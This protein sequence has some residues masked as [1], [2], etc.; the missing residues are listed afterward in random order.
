V[1]LNLLL[2]AIASSESTDTNIAMTA[3]PIGERINF[4][5]QTIL[6][7]PAVQQQHDREERIKL[8]ERKLAATVQAAAASLRIATPHTMHSPA[9]SVRTDEISL[10]QYDDFVSFVPGEVPDGK[11]LDAT[12][13]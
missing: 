11:T 1:H 3:G 10:S 5:L 4:N 7:H 8:T 12:F 6:K 13:A 9:G 2:F